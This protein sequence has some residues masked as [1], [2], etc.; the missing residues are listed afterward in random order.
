MHIVNSKICS[1]VVLV[2]HLYALIRYLASFFDDDAQIAKVEF[3]STFAIMSLIRAVVFARLTF[4]TSIYLFY[5]GHESI[6]A[7]KVIDSTII[8][9][10][11]HPRVDLLRLFFQSF[12]LLFQFFIVFNFNHQKLFLPR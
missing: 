3:L 4:D 8:I 2:V 11:E 9:H 10:F 6:A 1:D 12:I 5:F 7:F